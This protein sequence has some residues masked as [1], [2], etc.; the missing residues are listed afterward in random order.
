MT[1][2]CKKFN[3]EITDADGIRYISY[4]GV[5]KWYK[6]NF[7]LQIP[8]WYIRYKA[9]QN[10]GLVHLESANWGEFRGLA[11]A[12]H[13]NQIG[14]WVFPLGCPKKFNVKSFYEKIAKT[15]FA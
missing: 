12:D 8:Y 5:Q 15:D 11:A 14:W 3:E 10:D 1:E 4:A 7:I 6:V 9:G 2:S 13:W